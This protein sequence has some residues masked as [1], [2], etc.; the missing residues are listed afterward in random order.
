[1]W[2]KSRIFVVWKSVGMAHAPSA[3]VSEKE[4]I[5]FKP[6]FYPKDTGVP[7]EW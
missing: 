7:L 4:N 5:R 2:R 3:S 1:M 6:R